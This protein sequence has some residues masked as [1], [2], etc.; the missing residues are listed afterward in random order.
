[1]Y[2]YNLLCF[3]INPELIDT[4]VLSEI[5]FE[6]KSSIKDWGVKTHYHGGAGESPYTIGCIIS[7]DDNN[8]EYINLVRS[9][10]EEDYMENYNTFKAELLT[11]IISDIEICEGDK[12]EEYALEPLLSFK[13]IV[14]ETTPT[15]YAVQVSS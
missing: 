7:D 5:D 1:M 15:F 9:L 12:D 13:K 11:S 6:M 10:R 14:E 8:P 4:E 3:G 2:T